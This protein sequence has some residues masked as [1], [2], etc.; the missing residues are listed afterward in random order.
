LYQA[1]DAFAV[2]EYSPTPIPV[3]F[4]TQEYVPLPWS[5]RFPPLQA[6]RLENGPCRWN[7]TVAPGT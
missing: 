5:V 1:L 4:Q 3:E 7:E 6:D 2:T